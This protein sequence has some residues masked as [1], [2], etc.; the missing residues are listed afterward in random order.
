MT[1]NPDF[2]RW[3]DDFVS[4]Q[5]GYWDLWNRLA[6]ESL[7]AD[8]AAAQMAMG[9]W[10]VAFDRWWT[11]MQGA[12]PKGDLAP[13][14]G[15][16]ADQM[17]WY[18]KMSEGGTRYLGA[19]AGMDQ[20]T[21][22]WQQHLERSFEQFRQF[23]A[24]GQLGD[25]ADATRSLMSLGPQP[26]GSVMQSMGGLYAATAEIL[27]GLKGEFTTLM[28]PL[29]NETQR[30]LGIPA[31]GYR[32]E[33]QEQ[34]QR[35]MQ[36]HLAH[37]QAMNRFSTAMS[38][39]PSQAMDLMLQK[40][41]AMGERGETVSTLRGL[42]DLW[43]DSSE[44]VFARF[45][46]TDEYARLYGEVVNT[47]MAFRLH[48]QAMV[49]DALSHMNLPTRR[50]LDTQQERFQAL[51]RQVADLD[52]RLTG[53]RATSTGDGDAARR[54]ALLEEQVAR[55]SAQVDARPDQAVAP[56]PGNQAP[57]GGPA[58]EAPP[59]SGGSG[60]AARKRDRS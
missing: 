26:A 39:L 44:E 35:A 48:A 53:S 25:W 4:S 38:G 29:E 51:R 17:R 33:A 57:V 43:V 14:L 13:M 55:L 21:E 7:R 50:E 36:L 18:M 9:G 16:L 11:G 60:P 49:D 40:L 1:A 24:P 56:A 20:P 19:F 3:T 6:Q 23:M 10:T 41:T 42:Y 47:L 45:A 37:Q 34:V 32:R 31:I 59:R 30:L 8:P 5:R 52:Q 2:L 54:I 22:Q 12:L 15:S 27:N 46:L 28:G 58:P